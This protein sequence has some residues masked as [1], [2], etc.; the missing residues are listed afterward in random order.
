MTD[1]REA[2][3]RAIREAPIRAT[4]GSKHVDPDVALTDGE[5]LR[6][7]AAIAA[8]TAWNTRAPAPVPADVE[9]LA[10]RL[11]IFEGNLREHMLEQK[12][13]TERDYTLAARRFL[14]DAAT[15]LRAQAA[16]IAGLEAERGRL[17]G[18]LHR[19]RNLVTGG[20]LSVGPGD[21]SDMLVEETEEATRA[22]LIAQ[23][24]GE[25]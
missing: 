6:A 7:D 1:L 14:T 25:G 20:A 9:G 16:R 22:A 2:V 11:R 4:N 19:W 23:E 17:R 13:L 15:A 8:V 5:F 21:W 18:L 24:E 3:A 12:T 10:E